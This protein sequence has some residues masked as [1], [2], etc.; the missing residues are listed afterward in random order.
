LTL[1]FLESSALVKLFV[2][3]SGSEP[4]LTLI[5]RTEDRCKAAS[6][7]TPVELRSAIRR[8]QYAGDI[9]LADAELAVLSIREESRRIILHPV[10]PPVLELAAALVDR[11]NLRALDALQLSTAILASQSTDA[12]DQFKFIVSDKRLIVAAVAEGLEIWDPAD[13]QRTA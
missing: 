3:E 7:I 11:R 5:E 8:R 6:V 10:N 9:P 2:A 1:Y 12:A 13:E 4:I